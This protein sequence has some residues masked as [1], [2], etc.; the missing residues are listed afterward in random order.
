MLVWTENDLKSV[1]RTKTPWV[2]AFGHKPIYCKGSDCETFA[3]DFS[4]FDALLNKYNADLFISG[5]KHKF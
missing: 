4:A 1:D 3:S 5:H 2:I